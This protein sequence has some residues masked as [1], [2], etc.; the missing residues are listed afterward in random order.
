VEGYWQQQVMRQVLESAVCQHPGCAVM[1]GGRALSCT[2]NVAASEVTLPCSFDTCTLPAARS[3]VVFPWHS[4]RHLEYSNTD[5]AGIAG[6]VFNR[7]CWELH[8][9]VGVQPQRHAVSQPL[10][11]DWRMPLCLH[12]QLGSIALHDGNV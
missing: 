12:A 8:D 1:T 11:L 5:L 7:C 9:R 2:V 4:I 10:V 6:G 3:P